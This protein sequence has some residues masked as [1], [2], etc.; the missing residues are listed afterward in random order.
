MP[1]TAIF[2]TMILSIIITLMIIEVFIRK[3]IQTKFFKTFER[4][5]IFLS[6]ETMQDVLERYEERKLFL[7][8]NAIRETLEQKLKER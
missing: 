5:F 2:I 1:I 4:K 6:P 3:N 7:K 8:N